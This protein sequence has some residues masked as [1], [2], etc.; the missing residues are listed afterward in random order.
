[1]NGSKSANPQLITVIGTMPAARL[2]LHF[3]MLDELTKKHLTACG[4]RSPIGF[5]KPID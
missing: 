4:W 3:A 2:S 1:M 5:Y